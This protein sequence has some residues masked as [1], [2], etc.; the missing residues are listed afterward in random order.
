MSGGYLER[1]QS[2]GHQVVIFTFAGELPA[3]QI[4]D[5]N[6]AIDRLKKL[7]GS[8]ITGVTLRGEQSPRA[9]IKTSRRK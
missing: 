5:W 1:Q 6:D 2:R 4:R 8:K 7:F 3:E 9:R